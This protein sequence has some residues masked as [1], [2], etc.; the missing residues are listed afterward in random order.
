MAR[1]LLNW[2]SFW[3]LASPERAAEALVQFYGSDA[4]RAAAACALAADAD[5]RDDDYR[6]SLAVFYRL[7][8]AEQQ[9]TAAVNY[10]TALH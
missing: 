2:N 5:D 7:H 1:L 6:F 8:P 4:A 10:A 3:D 9:P